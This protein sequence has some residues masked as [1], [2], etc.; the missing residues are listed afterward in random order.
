VAINPSI[1]PTNLPDALNGVALKLGRFKEHHEA[2][3]EAMDA[4]RHSRPYRLVSEIKADGFVHEWRAV[5]VKQPS[6][7]VG[8]VIG[9]AIHNLRSCLDHLAWQL[10]MLT[11]LDGNQPPRSTE[12][13]IFKDRADYFAKDAD[14]NPRRGSGLYKV[15]HISEA[16][17]A[18]IEQLQPF[19]RPSP[20]GVRVHPL[21][22][23]QEL[24]NQD[25]HRVMNAAVAARRGGASFV[26]PDLVHEVWP[27]GRLE[28]N[29]VVLW[30]RFSVPSPDV[31]VN[32]VAM[33]DMEFE[34]AGPWDG[35][36]VSQTLARTLAGVISAVQAL[37]VLFPER[38]ATS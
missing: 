22:L 18:I 1:W 20:E 2:F 12:F 31:E 14:G 16:A 28:E 32:P 21:W 29:A 10:A 36:T 26:P 17:Q 33:V 24:S 38:G 9:D 8:V 7:H 11:M 30:R 37:K 3:E 19:Q 27:P 25:K 35:L 13:P 6:L 4:F 15:R 5:D 34:T 23:L